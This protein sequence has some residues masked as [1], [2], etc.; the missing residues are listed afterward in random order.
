MNETLLAQSRALLPR[1]VALRHRN[2]WHPELGDELPRTRAAVQEDLEDLEPAHSSAASGIVAALKGA[3]PGATFASQICPNLPSRTVACRPGAP[4]AAADS[5]AITITGKGGHG[6]IPHRANDLL[7][8]AMA[9]L[10]VA[11]EVVDPETAP[12][13]HSN[14]MIPGEAPMSRGVA[15]LAAVADEYLR[16]HGCSSMINLHSP[17]AFDRRD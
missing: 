10:G 7:P 8:G 9:F 16:Q 12:G 14:R 6:S 3:P 5:V 11:P 17:T 15:S 1:T 4:L 2:P 13:Y